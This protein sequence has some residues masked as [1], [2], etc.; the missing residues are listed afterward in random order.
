MNTQDKLWKGDFG[1]SYTERNPPAD[2]AGLWQKALRNAFE[3]PL[4]P[5]VLELGAGQGDNLAV[6]C[7][8]PE[9]IATKKCTGVEINPIAAAVMRS[10]GFGVIEDSVHNL[11]E[12]HDIGTWDLVI[13]RGFLIHVSPDDLPQVYR[14]MAN[15]ASKYVCIAEYFAPERREQRYQGHDHAMW[16]ADYAGEFLLLHPE[17]HLV[18]YG[19]YYDRDGGDNET[20]FLMG[21]ADESL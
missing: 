8:D 14:L 15:A 17:F 13:T 3:L 18:D 11:V 19:F 6:F 1:I 16:L 12:K 7:S 21:R 2:R 9:A 5:D 10:R 4:V 20:W